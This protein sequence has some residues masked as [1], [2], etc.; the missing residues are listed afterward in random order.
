M[1]YGFIGDWH[2]IC[3]IN[4]QMIKQLE[5]ANFFTPLKVSGLSGEVIN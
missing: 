1:S 3:L 5:K 4:S 2:S